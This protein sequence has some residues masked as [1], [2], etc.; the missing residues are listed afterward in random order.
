MNCSMH[1]CFTYMQPYR[2]FFTETLMRSRT[3]PLTEINYIELIETGGGGCV[4]IYDKNEILSFDV[5]LT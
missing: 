2:E 1:Y 4:A 3:Q 5:A